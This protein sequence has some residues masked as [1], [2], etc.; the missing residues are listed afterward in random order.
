[1]KCGMENLVLT[2]RIRFVFE[3]NALQVTATVQTAVAM[4]GVAVTA[5][6][7]LPIGSQRRAGRIVT[8]SSDDVEN[9]VWSPV[10]RAVAHTLFE[11]CCRTFW[12]GS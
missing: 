10:G 1:M 5:Q 6:S 3:A 2:D 9:E 7:C 11:T 12:C 8:D 4:G